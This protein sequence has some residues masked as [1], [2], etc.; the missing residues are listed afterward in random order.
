MEI[1]S[2]K[3]FADG[4]AI[5]EL[6]FLAKIKFTTPGGGLF[7]SETNSL[8]LPADAFFVVGDNPTNSFDSR[9]FGSVPLKAIYG[10]VTRI[11]W[12][13]NRIGDIR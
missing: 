10:K 3:L 8:S 7:P 11:Y 5:K 9:H 1:R 13:F 2:G 6:A 12:P 4:N